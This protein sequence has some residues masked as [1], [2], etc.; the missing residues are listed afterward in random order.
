[1]FL[2]LK[3][4]QKNWRHLGRTLQQ[5]E[6][7]CLCRDCRDLKYIQHQTREFGIGELTQHM[8]EM[9]TGKAVHHQKSQINISR[10]QS[11]LLIFCQLFMLLLMCGV[12]S[13]IKYFTLIIQK[14]SVDQSNYLCCRCHV[15]LY[16]MKSYAPMI[17]SRIF[18]FVI[19][20]NSQFHFSRKLSFL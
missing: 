16:V 20:N 15:S 13:C 18:I 9:P 4:N 7:I 19:L 14:C 10:S 8:S 12:Q 1:M 17:I 11:C 5:R 2:N 3:K 6:I